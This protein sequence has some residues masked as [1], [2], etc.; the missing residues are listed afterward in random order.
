MTDARPETIDAAIA[1]DAFTPAVGSDYDR[2]V[3]MRST[4]RATVQRGQQ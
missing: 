4:P 2:P 3:R 1:T